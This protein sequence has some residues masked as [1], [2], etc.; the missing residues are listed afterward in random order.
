MGFLTTEEIQ[1]AAEDVA[2]SYDKT[3]WTV[4]TVLVP[5]GSGD[6]VESILTS[7]PFPCRIDNAKRAPQEL[8]FGGRVQSRN[9]H[10]MH[11]PLY[12]DV[13]DSDRVVSSAGVTYEVVGTNTDALSDAIEVV[14][15]LVVL[16]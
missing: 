10:L 11:C 1:A 12:T 14:I 3:A 16:L 5:D 9:T 6:M 15:T 7:A 8:V 2:L 4:R 13:L